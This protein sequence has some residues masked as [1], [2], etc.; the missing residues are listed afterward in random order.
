M[1]PPEIADST[2]AEGRKYIMLITGKLPDQQSFISSI[3]GIT[4][5]A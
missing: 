5:I 3:T 1:R 4:G 2:E